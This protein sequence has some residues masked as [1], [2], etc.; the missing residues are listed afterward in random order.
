MMGGV[1][2]FGGMAVRRG[3]AAADIAARPAQTK[4]DPIVTGFQAIDT[5]FGRGFYGKHGPNVFAIFHLSH[6]LALGF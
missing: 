3:I 5:A 1:I 4:V 2:V 6:H